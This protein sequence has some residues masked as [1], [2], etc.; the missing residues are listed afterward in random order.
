[1]VELILGTYGAL[2]WLVFAK[3]KLIPLNTYT[4]TDYATSPFDFAP[5]IPTQES[6]DVIDDRGLL[7]I[8]V[9]LNDAQ[10]A[11]IE[12]SESMKAA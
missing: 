4:G 1:M 12:T 5:L 11:P 6:W 10:D 9:T 8:G 2:C 3:F 7:C